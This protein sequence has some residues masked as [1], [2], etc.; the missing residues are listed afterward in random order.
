MGNNPSR[1]KWGAGEGL[2][3]G[4][5]GNGDY[6]YMRAKTCFENKYNTVLLYSPPSRVRTEQPLGTT[7]KPER[8]TPNYRSFTRDF[9]E[10]PSAE[11]IRVG[12][13]V[14]VIR[15]IAVLVAIHFVS[16]AGTHERRKTAG[17]SFR[18]FLIS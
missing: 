4:P 18:S 8:E 17:E 1:E 13:A 6:Y 5:A 9:A 10:D 3:V 12:V 11:T 14:V 15:E 7:S 16:A 2:N